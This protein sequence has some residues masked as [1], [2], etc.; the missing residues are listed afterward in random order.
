LL[1]AGDT[2]VR[3]PQRAR[4]LLQDLDPLPDNTSAQELATLLRQILDE[5]DQARVAISKLKKQAR[6]QHHRIQELEEQQRA[7]TD[8]EQNIQQRDIQPGLE[9]GG[10]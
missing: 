6:K 10:Q 3:D 7:L 4:E 9:N 1:T 8:I 5:R 2:T